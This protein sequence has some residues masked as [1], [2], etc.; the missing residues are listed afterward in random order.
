MKKFPL[1]LCAAALLC[2]TALTG[3]GSDNATSQETESAV[4]SAV[5]STD[6]IDRSMVSASDPEDDD[7]SFVNAIDA[8][9]IAR[10]SANIDGGTVTQNKLEIEDGVKVYNITLEKPLIRFDFKIRASDGEILSRDVDYSYTEALAI[11]EEAAGVSAETVTKNA[12]DTDDGVQVFEITFVTDSVEYDFEIDAAT[13]DIR[14]QE[15]EALSDT[16]SDDDTSTSSLSS[17][18]DQTS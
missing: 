16:V 14:K 8:T 13:G 11:A 3:C 15:Q 1:I 7:S 4:S 6:D 17:A 5:E 10:E 9:A 12:L 2:G 18:E